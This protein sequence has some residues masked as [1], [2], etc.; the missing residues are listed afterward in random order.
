MKVKW[1]EKCGFK[2]DADKGEHQCESTGNQEK[3]EKK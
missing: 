2:Y 1:C 3:K